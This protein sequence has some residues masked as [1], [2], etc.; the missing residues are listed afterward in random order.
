VKVVWRDLA[1][2]GQ[3]SVWAAEAASCAAE[4]D[5][6]WPYH[7]KL[8]AEQAGR[9]RGAFSRENLKR[10]GQEIGLERQPFEACVEAGRYAG[11]VQAERQAG[12]AKGVSSTPTLFVGGSRL[13]GV[14]TFEQLSQAIEAAAGR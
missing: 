12:E 2:L 3:E 14:P 10:F 9:N 6:F 7:D 4:Q 11:L 8:F 13:Q 5:R 1:F